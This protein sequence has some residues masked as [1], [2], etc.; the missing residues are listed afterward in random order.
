MPLLMT[1]S[2]S[3]HITFP[4]LYILLVSISIRTT[5]SF[6]YSYSHFR[7]YLSEKGD[8]T[9]F[10]CSAYCYTYIFYDSHTTNSQEGS[11]FLWALVYYFLVRKKTVSH[12]FLLNHAIYTYIY[13]IFLS[14]KTENDYSEF[15]P[16]FRDLPLFAL[17]RENWRSA[18]K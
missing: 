15:V 9:F 18:Y 3:K 12:P 5:L 4:R 1:T 14:L 2:L 8:W 6:S 10:T 17:P 16:Y 7:L 13:I 11:L